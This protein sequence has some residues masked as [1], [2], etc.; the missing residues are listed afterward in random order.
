MKL[1]VTI[2]LLLLFQ[3]INAQINYLIVGTYDSP[4]SEGI[5]I[6]KFDSEKG[7]A[8]EISH[9]KS[10]NPSFLAI[11][12]D[13]K[14][15][16]AVS[17]TATSTGKLGEVV[18]FS[19]NKVTG[20][21]TFLNKQPSLGDNPCHVELDKTGKW[22]FVSNYTSGTISCLP[23]K[24]DGTL[25]A[26]TTIQHTGS[27]PNVE[28]QKSAHAHGA[29]ISPDNTML[30]V[31]DLG[32]D[33]LMQYDFDET[34]GLLSP[35]TPAFM[36]SVAGAGPRLFAYQPNHKTAY[37]IEELS[38]TVQVYR[39]KKNRLNAI[40]RIST[41]RKEDTQ[42]AGSA[43]IHTS[44]DGKF[45]YASNRGEANTIAIF[46]VRRN[47]KLNLIGQQSTL[48][49]TPRNFSIDPSGKFLLVGNQNSNEIVVFNRNIKTG[50]LT[51]AGQRINVGKPV[52]LKWASIF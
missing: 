17:E 48:G 30:Y 38:G 41:M 51:D 16:Y 13:E 44:P 14:F 28:R 15:V 18:A 35:A 5:Y 42:F 20:V 39:N 49:K 32:I 6:Y 21:L 47:G 9:T 25:G 50:L 36:P 4:K 34:T 33:K 22:I 2:C 27:G 26:G 29:I 3:S 12:K 7:T 52:C 19:F 31:T 1:V 45:L 8:T 23:I 11:S 24:E 10:A 40:Q 43:D 46:K 37:V